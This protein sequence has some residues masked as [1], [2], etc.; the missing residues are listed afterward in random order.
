VKKQ[1]RSSAAGK[2][3]KSDYAALLGEV[4]E[5]IRAAQYAALRAVNKE[6][7]ALYW[8]I[9]GLIIERQQ[10]KTWGKSVVERLA[11]DLQ[12]EFPG[13]GGFSARNIWYMRNFYATYCGNKK[14]QP[15]VAEISWSHNL[16]IMERCKDD[17]A[18]EF[19]LRR[20]RECGWTKHALTRQI[21]LRAYEKTLL[22][23][24]NFDRTVTEPR[25]RQA[26]L[27]VKDEYTFDFLELG[28]QFS[29]R[30]LEAEAVTKVERFLNEMG[31]RFA[32][33]GRQ[34]RLE[35]EGQEFF[36]DL[37]LFHRLL[38]CLVALEFKTGEFQ[39]EHVGKMQFYLAVLDDRVR[40]PDENPPI[41]IILCR[42][43]RRTVVEY[44][45]RESNKPIGVATY[46]VVGELPSELQGQLPSPE[47]IAELLA[48][49][50]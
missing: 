24:T 44:T 27:A 19:Y 17:L 12:A 42:N 33:V 5:R 36:I 11:Q 38:R 18:R 28:D 45:L 10:G 31:G 30:E 14:L 35:V 15:L 3:A 43:R 6:L 16:I 48:D 39:P 21:D 32:F 1:E 49:E 46:R 34:F 25:R 50:E 41:G 29:E 7:I 8:D 2:A 23:Q 9:G 37:L 47:Q 20:T 13:V 22:S 26:K 4:K 40:L